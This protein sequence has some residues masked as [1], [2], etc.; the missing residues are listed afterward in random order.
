MG[1]SKKIKKKNSIPV[2]ESDEDLL[3]A[4]EGASKSESDPKNGPGKKKDSTNRHGLPVLD[5]AQFAQ[6]T[7]EDDSSDETADFE[8]LL[9][10]SF[11]KKKPKPRQGAAKP[12]KIKKRLK[13]Y[14]PPEMDL[15]L[16]GFTAIGAELKTKNFLSSCKQQGYFTVRIIVGKGL[17]SDF[18]AV[19]PDVIEDVVKAMKQQHIVLSYKWERKKKSSSGAMIVYLKQFDAFD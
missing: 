13:R 1:K 4:F 19:L 14:P 8:H 18:G 15:D 11:K 5:D 12:L 3:R 10:E 9:E 7:G 2:F 6:M 17:H 16:H